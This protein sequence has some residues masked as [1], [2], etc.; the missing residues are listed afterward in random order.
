MKLDQISFFNLASRRMEWLAARQQ[1]VSENVANADTPGF[2]ARD[3]SDFSEM[4]G[5][6]RQSGVA[7][8]NAR[9]ITGESVGSLRV[10]D[11]STA[12]ETSMDGN[13]VVLEQQTIKANE[14][15]ESYRLA[16]RLYSK[17]HELLTMSVT[18]LR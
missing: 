14:I 4:V 1:V 15:S 2:K 5:A 12:W 11:D 9:H 8:T 18:G 6:S 13:T 16:S 7:T 17:G 10:E 3:V